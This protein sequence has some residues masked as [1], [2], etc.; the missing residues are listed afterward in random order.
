MLKRS[1]AKIAKICGLSLMGMYILVA[2]TTTSNKGKQPSESSSNMSEQMES[3]KVHFF[4]EET[5][6]KDVVENPTASVLPNG[7]TTEHTTEKTTDNTTKNTTENKT[8]ANSTE[9]SSEES[10][11]NT[12][13]DTTK[14]SESEEETTSQEEDTT[15]P[16]VVV[17]PFYLTKTEFDITELSYTRLQYYIKN[18]PGDIVWTSEDISVAQVVN[19]E[20]I[21][22]SN[23]NTSITGVSGDVT[24]TISVKVES[25]YG[26]DEETDT[27]EGDNTVVDESKRIFIATEHIYLFMDSKEE[28][29]ATR[30]DELKTALEAILAEVESVT[31]YSFTDINENVEFSNTR[32]RVVIQAI[33]T[34][35]IYTSTDEI[36][37]NASYMDFEQYGA[38]TLVSEL[39][40]MIQ[41]RNGV[42]LGAALSEGYAEYLQ[43][44]VCEKLDYEIKY[45]ATAVQYE[46]LGNIDEITA[47]NIEERLLYPNDGNPLSYFFVEYIASTYGDAK[48]KEVADAI[49]VKAVEMYGSV[50]A[51]QASLFTEEEIL[52]IIEGNTAEGIIEDF[53]RYIS[54]Y[55]YITESIS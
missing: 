26:D 14:P 24:V 7:D 3:S 51:G 9:V 8:T 32:K 38:H 29:D 27:G 12:T 2:C 15:T 16:D 35:D 52:T 28:L 31:G 6:S 39:L 55:N 50:L 17:E 49:T 18:N 23:G 1:L 43:S 53:Y 34:Q 40:R 46:K 22:I 13:S 54:E 37:I 44:K 19:D 20:L 10:T 30:V 25:L 45:D 21:G 5:T 48:I 36:V 41:F 33:D 47:E 11:T 4:E 42:D